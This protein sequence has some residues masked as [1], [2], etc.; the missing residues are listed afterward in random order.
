MTSI[1]LSEWT[2]GVESFCRFSPKSTQLPNIISGVK[3][4]IEKRCFDI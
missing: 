4:K 2:A 3:D 1:Q